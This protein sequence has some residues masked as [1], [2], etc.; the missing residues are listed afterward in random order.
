MIED[1]PGPAR[2]ISRRD[3]MILP[4]VYGPANFV[5]P[6]RDGKDM[7][8][9]GVGRM[10][11]RVGA[12]GAAGARIARAVQRAVRDGRLASD[13]L[14]DVDLAAPRP[15]DRIDVRA[16]HPEGGPESLPV[17]DADPCLEEIGRAS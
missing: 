13:V 16:E 9:V 1:P 5:R 3:A 11:E 14:H 8:V 7:K 6:P 10:R 15:T 17:R 12:A 2:Q 4:A